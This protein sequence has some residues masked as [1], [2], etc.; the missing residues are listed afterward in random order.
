MKS[1]FNI[2]SHNMVRLAAMNISKQT[3]AVEKADKF[4]AEENLQMNRKTRRR[5]A[6]RLKAK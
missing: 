1:S 6:K 3:K 4:I 5:I 2:G